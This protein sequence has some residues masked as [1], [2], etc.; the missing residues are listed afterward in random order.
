[1]MV[2]SWLLTDHVFMYRNENLFQLS[3]L[4]FALIPLL[5]SVGLSGRRSALAWRL[6]AVVAALSVLGLLLQLIPGLDQGNGQIIALALPVHLGVAWGTRMLASS[7]R[8]AHQTA[9]PSS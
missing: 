3:P 8:A 1:V 6:A 2:A 5:V 9:R 7:A 4:S